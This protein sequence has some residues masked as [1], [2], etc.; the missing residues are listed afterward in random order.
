MERPPALLLAV[1][2]LIDCT[3]APSGP[4]LTTFTLPTTA[5]AVIIVT[6]RLEPELGAAAAIGSFARAPKNQR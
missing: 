4:T 2:L 6:K 5:P 3:T 1:R